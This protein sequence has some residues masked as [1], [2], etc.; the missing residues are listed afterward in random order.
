M[1]AHLTLIEGHMTALKKNPASVRPNGK[2]APASPDSSGSRF[3]IDK[4]KAFVAEL[5]VPFSPALIEWR[6]G[7]VSEDRSRGQVIPY[8]DQR[9]YTDRLNEL[10]TPA[11]W[12]RKYTVHT[13]ATFERSRDNKVAA[14][15]FVTCDLTIHGIGSH[16]ATGEEWT[17]NENAGTSAEAQA[18]KRACS[19]FGLGRYLYDLGGNWVDLDERKQ[20]L[21]RPQLPDWALPMRKP[22]STGHQ[23]GH[24]HT[25]GNGHLKPLALSAQALADLRTKV[26]SLCEQVGFGLAKSVTRSIA[27]GE[28]PD[29]IQDAGMLNAMSMKLEDT[30]R[31]VERLRAATDVVGQTTFCQVCREMNLAGDC[32]DDIPDRRTLRQLIEALET[33]AGATPLQQNG[34]GH[35]GASA[36]RTSVGCSNELG[37]ARADLVREAQR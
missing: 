23:N 18:F 25:N 34:N 15:V 4:V 6:V 9:A 37:T 19:C 27:S 36:N 5:E 2:S 12:T 10:F 13:S 17:D 33:R 11:G 8:A 21:S 16:S 1:K 20:P 3:N 22:V 28:N 32:L 30:L 35:G 31:G 24:N 7:K 14:K 29:E 26:K